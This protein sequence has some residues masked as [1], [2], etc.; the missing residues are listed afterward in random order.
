MKAIKILVSGALLLGAVSLL[1]TLASA[2]EHEHSKCEGKCDGKCEMRGHKGH[3]MGDHGYMEKELA[4]TDAQKQTL[5]TQRAAGQAEREAL[6]S[7]IK[8]A[9][10]ALDS[11]VA[12]GA[13]DSELKAK[14]DAL[15]KLHAQ[16][17]LV[18]AKQHKAFEAVLTAEQKQKLTELKAK[19]MERMEQR[20]TMHEEKA[21]E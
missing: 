14:S 16:Q 17:A 15:G 19:R 10:A 20:K 8:D 3:K 6:H 12:A 18:S 2:G 5:K 9:R 21:K 11:A 13:K 1:P 7:K 4:L